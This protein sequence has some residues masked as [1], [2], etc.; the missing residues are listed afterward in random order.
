MVT[1]IA[2]IINHNVWIQYTI[3]FSVETLITHIIKVYLISVF[4]HGSSNPVRDTSQT[5]VFLCW[6]KTLPNRDLN[7]GPFVKK[8]L[9]GTCST[10]WAISLYTSLRHLFCQ[11]WGVYQTL[12]WWHFGWSV[13]R[14]ACFQVQPI[15]GS[16]ILVCCKFLPVL[17]V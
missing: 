15:S 13:W 4:Q 12:L 5:I 3:S 17:V 7:S 9:Q 16:M 8:N 1:I 6:R 10:I 14:S 11:V 2:I